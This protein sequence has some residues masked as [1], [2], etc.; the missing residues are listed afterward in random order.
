MYSFSINMALSLKSVSVCTA[1]M[2]H[3]T[4]GPTSHIHSFIFVFSSQ[5]RYHHK[6][7]WLNW[8]GNHLVW[9]QCWAS[10]QLQTPHCLQTQD[11][12]NSSKSHW[13]KRVQLQEQEQGAWR[14]KAL[15]S[16]SECSHE[17]CSRADNQS[18][19]Q[20][21]RKNRV[22]VTWRKKLR[23][24]NCPPLLAHTSRRAADCDSHCCRALHPHTLLH[25]DI[26]SDFHM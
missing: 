25:S 21:E 8:T 1:F 13:C 3:H 5:A 7:L 4:W 18:P 9:S 15:H 24:K 26:H 11:Q 12:S 14:V 17:M 23:A 22:R 19:Q 10:P 20:G 2:F 6:K 16:Q